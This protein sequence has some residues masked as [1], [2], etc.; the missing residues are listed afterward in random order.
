[1]T[2]TSLSE[3]ADFYF[4]RFGFKPVIIKE[5]I[6]PETKIII[7][8]PC[9]D[10]PD[11]M[12]TL[13]SLTQC[14]QPVYP[15]E[16]IVVINHSEHADEEVIAQNKKT[17]Y[18][19]LAWCK[20]LD[21][22]YFTFHLLYIG[23][24]PAKHAGVGLARKI[25]MDE[26]LRRFASIQYSGLILCLDADCTV[27]GNYLQAIEHQFLTH[28]PY[29]CNIYFEHVPDHVQEP[30]LKEGILFYE[31][32]LR[33]Y[34]NALAY[35]GFPFAMHTI[36]SSMAVRADIYAKSGGMNRR[37]AGEDFYFLHKIAPL[38]HFLHIHQTTVFPSARVSHRVPFGTGRAQ[39]NWLQNPAQGHFTYHFQTFHDLQVFLKQINSYYGLGKAQL[40]EKVEQLPEA[41]SNF[42]E[43]HHFLQK[44]EEMQQNTTSTEAFVKRFFQWFNGFTVLKYVHFARDH[45]YQQQPLAEAASQ[46]YL[47]LTGQ[48]IKEPEYL[49]QHFRNLDRKSDTLF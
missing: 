23:D 46:L 32:Y 4:R 28:T 8:I 34:V 39:A 40:A 22:S 6:N 38:K 21:N 42:L 12:T 19:A 47:C 30:E 2:N 27:K 31:L 5:P 29:A 41:V 15:V 16:I 3:F 33:Y 14:H 17:L 45:F 13:Q 36:G 18:Q 1:M 9:H 49:L 11:L 10:E 20:K 43:E 25:G 7:V 24:L 48:A 44:V 35:S 26:A 37:K